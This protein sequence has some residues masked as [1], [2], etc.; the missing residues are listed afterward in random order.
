[1]FD[2]YLNFKFKGERTY[3]Q[4]GDIFDALEEACSKRDAFI[5]SLSM[6]HLTSK[7][8]LATTNVSQ[9]ALS[10]GAAK[11][12]CSDGSSHILNLYETSD[13]NGRYEF[14]EKEITKRTC[15]VGLYIETNHQGNYSTVENIIAITKALCN[16]LE[17]LDNS[18][19]LFG[20]LVLQEKLPSVFSSLRVSR[21]ASIPSRFNKN[22][23]CLDEKI[24]GEI[25]FIAAPNA[26]IK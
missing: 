20:Q 16:R 3:V 15:S 6:R 14:I 10:V 22:E 17:P 26:S 24:I 25:N 18:R 7:N 1:M 9:T 2:L 19:W 4:G 23:I 12:R 8:L 13:V 21:K 5:T 11:I